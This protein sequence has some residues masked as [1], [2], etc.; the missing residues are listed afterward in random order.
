MK[1]YDNHG[2]LC[3]EQ[4][5]FYVDGKVITTNT[6]YT[7]YGGQLKV[8]SQMISSSDHKTGKASS[9]IVI[10]GGLLP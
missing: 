8:Q 1:S 6:S 4:N 7:N 2:N 10:G 5:T 9:T 3:N